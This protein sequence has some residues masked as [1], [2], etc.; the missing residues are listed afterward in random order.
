[1]KILKKKKKNPKSL[2]NKT[3]EALTSKNRQAAIEL[4]FAF[5]FIDALAQLIFVCSSAVIYEPLSSLSLVQEK[6]LLSGRS[7]FSLNKG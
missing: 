7:L 6:M 3:H 5:G 4:M 2:K 1:M